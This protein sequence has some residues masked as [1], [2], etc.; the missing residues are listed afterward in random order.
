MVDGEASGKKHSCPDCAFCQWC[1][2]DRC[3]LCLD[4]KPACRRKLSLREQI[5]L[6]EAVNRGEKSDGEE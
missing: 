5:A 2:D 4:R 3:R 1:G 6:Y